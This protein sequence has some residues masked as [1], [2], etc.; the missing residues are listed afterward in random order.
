M[1]RNLAA[2]RGAERPGER[3][4]SSVEETRQHEAGIQ[5]PCQL[6][7]E[8]ARRSGRMQARLEGFQVGLLRVA[9]L[10][11]HRFP[12]GRVPL[13]TLAGMKEQSLTRGELQDSLK[14]CFVREEVSGG[15]PFGDGGP[16]DLCVEARRQ[17]KRRAGDPGSLFPSKVQVLESAG[18]DERLDFAGCPIS[19]DQR[20]RR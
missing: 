11:S 6:V 14:E 8:T 20:E 5:A 7:G 15:D 13:E 9:L 10:C 17:G 1:V 16:I 2:M 3:T 12:I 19:E 4:L 18:I